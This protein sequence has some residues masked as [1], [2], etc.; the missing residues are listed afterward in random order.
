MSY[1]GGFSNV[2]RPVFGHGL[3][4]IAT[5][6]NSRHCSHRADGTGDVTKTHI[7]WKLDRGAP[8]TPSPLLAGDE[9]Y[10]VSDIGIAT[11]LDAKTGEV[12]WRERLPGNYSASP[13]LA[14]GRIYFQSEEGVTTILAPGRAFLKLGTSSLD[15]VTLASIAVSGGSFFIRTDRFLYR[16]GRSG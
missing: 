3:V 2:P 10:I 13:I 14:D 1:L 4:F 7:A 9:L 8:H 15:G 16:I 12:R 6:F 5:G 11:C